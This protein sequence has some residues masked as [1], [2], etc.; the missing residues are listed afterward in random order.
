MTQEN[1]NDQITKALDQITEALVG[2][3]K[4]RDALYQLIQLESARV[5]SAEDRIDILMDERGSRIANENAK[6]GQAVE[7]EHLT[8]GEDDIFRLLNAKEDFEKSI[9]KHLD[10]ELDTITKTTITPKA[11]LDLGFTEEY[12]SDEDGTPG[13]IYYNFSKHG[14]D[15]M[16]N[17][18]RGEEPL[19]V[20]LENQYEVHNLR[21]LGDLILSLTELR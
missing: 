16:T 18:V 3:G 2:G 13:Y 8:T 14:V 20:F 11:L 10:K 7:P 17:E 12:Q 6:K 19:Y 9:E 5:D 15:L 4:T 1:I 21:K